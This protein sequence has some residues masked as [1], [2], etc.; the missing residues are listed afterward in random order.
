MGKPGVMVDTKP[1]LSDSKSSAGAAGMPDL[2][3]VALSV[4]TTAS[5][6]DDEL[7]RVAKESLPEIVDALTKALPAEKAKKAE[8]F[9]PKPAKVLSFTGKEYADAVENM[10]KYFLQNRWIMLVGADQKHQVLKRRGMF[11]R[12]STQH[13]G[14]VR[15]YRRIV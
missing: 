6:P 10:E 8:P 9:K 3:I 11:R 1:F 5:R 2:K 15:V 7:Q 14:Q 13:T 4:P 12:K